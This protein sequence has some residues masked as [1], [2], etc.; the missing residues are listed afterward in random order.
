MIYIVYLFTKIII[1]T[2]CIILYDN[3]QHNIK[4]LKIYNQHTKN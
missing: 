3:Y 2:F 4:M 1:L